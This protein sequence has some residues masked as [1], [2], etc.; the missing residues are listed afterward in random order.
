MGPREQGHCY[1]PVFDMVQ[2][3]I[4]FEDH[5]QSIQE[6]PGR[7]W[8][9]RQSLERLDQFLPDTPVFVL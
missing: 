8:V 3:L 7:N 2:D 9:P 4:R 1:V 6:W 5:A